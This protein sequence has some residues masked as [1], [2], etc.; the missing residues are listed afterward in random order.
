MK[1]KHL[2]EKLSLIRAFVLVAILTLAAPILLAPAT[3]LAQNTAGSSACPK[4]MVGKAGVCF[5][6]TQLPSTSIEQL[7]LNFMQ[8]L[9]GIFG[10]LAIITFIIAGIQYMAA[11][12]NPDTVKR[13]K[14]NLIYS[15]IGILVALS[16]FIIILSIADFLGG[17]QTF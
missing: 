16:G 9:F 4:G 10:F 7:L 17:S 6:E 14:Q 15:V 13:A 3:A 11:A 2:K 1:Q 8:W 5:P 12:G